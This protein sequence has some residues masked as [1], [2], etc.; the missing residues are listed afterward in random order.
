MILT[1]DDADTDALGAAYALSTA[2][3]GRIGVPKSIA[4]F[5]EKFSEDLNLEIHFQPVVGENEVVIIVDAADHQ[6]L[7]GI[8]LSQYAVID[9]HKDNKLLKEAEAYFHEVCDSTCQMVFRLLKFMEIALTKKTATALAAGI[10]GDTIYLEQASGETVSILGNIL[11]EGGITYKD[12][13]MTMRVGGKLRRETKLR[14]AINAKL[15]R[16]DDYLLV[17]TQT[18]ANYVYYVA[19]MF[20][21]LGADIALVSHRDREEVNIRLVKAP[22]INDEKLNLLEIIKKATAGTTIENLWGDENF[23][24]FKGLDKESTIIQTILDNISDL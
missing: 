4:E 21:E 10:L 1:H 22:G 13:L 24:G 16:F 2:L 17:F 19:M 12:V 15:Y 23:V 8:S 20:I 3:G 11:V 14:A 18:Q 9:H 5:T 7:P 6:Q